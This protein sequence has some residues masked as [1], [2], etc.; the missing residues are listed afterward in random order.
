MN[1]EEWMP[2]ETAPADELV[3][4][5]KWFVYK[6][7]APEW[8][9]GAEVVWKSGWFGAAKRTI[10]SEGYSHWKPLPKPPTAANPNPLTPDEERALS[11][12]R[13]FRSYCP[14]DAS[15]GTIRHSLQDQFVSLL[16]SLVRKKYAIVEMTDDGPRYHAS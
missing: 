1:E 15:P 11:A 3:M 10:Y 13:K 7:S 9:Q 5:G 2:I 14:G 12:L 16:Q 4:V 8:H 6:T